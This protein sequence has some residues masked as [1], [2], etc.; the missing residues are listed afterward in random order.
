MEDQFVETAKVNLKLTYWQ[1]PKNLEPEKLK[2]PSAKRLI[3]T[4][5]KK[6]SMNQIAINSYKYKKK[7]GLI[8]FRNEPEFYALFVSAL[9]LSEADFVF[10][11]H[12]FAKGM[13][14]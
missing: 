3:N 7:R 9:L 13:G 5:K 14:Y 1:A 8:N 12:S 4:V 2:K 10:R 11:R 6:Q